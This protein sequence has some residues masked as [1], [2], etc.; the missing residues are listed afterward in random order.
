MDP[1]SGMERFEAPFHFIWIG[2]LCNVSIFVMPFKA[3][4][5]MSLGSCKLF[6]CIPE[7]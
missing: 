5:D 4:R 7:E 3:V 6:L 2:F 1:A